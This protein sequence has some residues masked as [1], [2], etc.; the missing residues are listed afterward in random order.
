[1]KRTVIFALVAV[2]SFAF[3][4]VACTNKNG[5]ETTAISDSA[6]APVADTAVESYEDPNTIAPGLSWSDV[7]S[8][9]EEQKTTDSDSDTDTDS[10]RSS[11]S[12]EESS[13]IHI[14]SGIEL[15]IIPLP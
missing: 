14:E 15:P 1:M 4:I 9:L 2:L 7:Y 6:E 3:V 11:D 13:E 5:N 12:E 8:M 10:E